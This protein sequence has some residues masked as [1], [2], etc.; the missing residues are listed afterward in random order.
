MA[1]VT[2]D[3]TVVQTD[4]ILSA[5]TGTEILALDEKY[6]N[7]FSFSGSGRLIW[8]CTKQPI[9]VRDICVRLRTHYKIDEKTCAAETL[10]YINALVAEQLLRVASTGTK[11]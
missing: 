2:L 1:D 3:D 10:A 6:G 9:R 8:Q 5:D 11:G 7:C 4:A